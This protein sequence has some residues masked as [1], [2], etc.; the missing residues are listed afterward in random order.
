MAFN[1]FTSPVFS[2]CSPPPSSPVPSAWP[3]PSSSSSP[4]PAGKGMAT[5]GTANNRRIRMEFSF[6]LSWA[7]GLLVLAVDPQPGIGVEEVQAM[8]VDH[9]LDRLPLGGAGAGGQAGHEV[10]PAP[11]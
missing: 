9:E 4:H 2:P 8:G 3:P 7:C 5:A 6:L 1:T 10:R 11:A